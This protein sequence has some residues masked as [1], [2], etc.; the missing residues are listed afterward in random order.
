MADITSSPE[1]GEDKDNK[2]VTNPTLDPEQRYTPLSPGSPV[3]SNNLNNLARKLG[4]KM[5]TRK[6][7][8]KLSDRLNAQSAIEPLDEQLKSSMKK[9]LHFPS[10]II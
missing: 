6:S 3:L 2:T 1:D 4:D 8:V 10:I 5:F 9:V 7:R